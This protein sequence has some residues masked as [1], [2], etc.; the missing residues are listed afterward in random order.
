MASRRKIRLDTA[1]VPFRCSVYF[2]PP[3]HSSGQ[4]WGTSLL[5]PKCSLQSQ[6]ESAVQGPTP[7][8]AFLVQ[9]TCKEYFLLEK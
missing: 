2:S 8:L 9:V 4:W 3:N 1:H 6:V 7:E 5:H